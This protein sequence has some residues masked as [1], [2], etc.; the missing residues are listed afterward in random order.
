MGQPRHPED[1]R[2]SSFRLVTQDGRYAAPANRDRG[3]VMQK[4]ERR[5][6]ATRRR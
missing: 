2:T 6:S 3:A 1:T 5:P 4:A